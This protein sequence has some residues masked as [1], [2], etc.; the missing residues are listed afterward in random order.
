MMDAN[1]DFC[2]WTRDNLPPSDSTVRLK[3][4]I[5][6]LFVT[7]FP[8]GV[9]QVVTVPTRS[10]PG[11]AD[12]GLDPIYTNKPEK[13]S[14]VY[15]EFAGGS[16]HKLVKVTRYA[17]SLK[18]NVRYVRKRSFK[19]FSDHNFQAAVSNLS[20]WDIYICEDKLTAILD[21]MAQKKTIQVRS[22]Y[23]PWLS[24]S[25]KKLM[26]D[27]NKAELTATQTKDDWQHC[28]MV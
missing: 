27:R 6:L 15:A 23:A 13:L 12:A 4:L 17:K 11:Q 28:L 20:C 3:S 21:T 7:I 1:L 5:D 25:T 2:K 16:D 8:H 18:K 14:S 22:K 10:W 9:S 26:A 24:N 19:N